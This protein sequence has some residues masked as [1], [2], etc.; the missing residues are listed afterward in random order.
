MLCIFGQ[1][2]SQAIYKI[3]HV[4]YI[5]SAGQPSNIQNNNNIR[6]VPIYTVSQLAKQYIKY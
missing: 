4:M 5:R 6:Y 1:P 3:L 2:V